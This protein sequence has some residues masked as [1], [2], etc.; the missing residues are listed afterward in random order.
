MSSR[1]KELRR[2]H[3]ELT[4]QGTVVNNQSPAQRLNSVLPSV[5]DA[6]DQLSNGSI[7]ALNAPIA[8]WFIGSGEKVF[9]AHISKAVSKYRS[10]KL[11]A[12]V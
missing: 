12:I 6:P 10:P 5:R 9:N 3:K 1:L 7:H 11:R 2:R 4:V 8:G